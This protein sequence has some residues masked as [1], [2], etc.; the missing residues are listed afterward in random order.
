MKDKKYEDVDEIKCMFRFIENK[1]NHECDIYYKIS[2]LEG[3]LEVSE[4]LEDEVGSIAIFDNALMLTATGMFG[5]RTISQSYN[6][7]KG[8]YCNLMDESLL[9]YKDKE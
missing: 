6:F 4:R 7:H 1:V 5:Y 2:T 9:C 8:S 3:D